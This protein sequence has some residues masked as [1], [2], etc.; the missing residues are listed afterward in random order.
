MKLIIAGS[1]NYE[2][3]GEYSSVIFNGL[4]AGIVQYYGVTEIISGL[5][6]GPDS[7]GKAYG[8]EHGIKVVEF[9]AEWDLLGKKA[10]MVRNHQMGD[11]ADILVAFWDGESKGTKDMIDY[12][13]KLK[14]Q[15]IVENYG[16]EDGFEE[17]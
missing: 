8:I 10:G 17:W 12:M 11:Y 1:R 4:I 9:P 5:A 15:V 3:S 16:I 13:S 6:K 14:K 2:E 7:M